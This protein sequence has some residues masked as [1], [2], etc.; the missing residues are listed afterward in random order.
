MAKVVNKIKREAGSTVILDD[1]TYRF[2]AGNEHT[3]EVVNPAHLER[4]RSI[5]SFVVIEDTD[6]AEPVRRTRPRKIVPVE[7]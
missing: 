4:F 6:P 3:A 5:S 7:E 2:F 1:V